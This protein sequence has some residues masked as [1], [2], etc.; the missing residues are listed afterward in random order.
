MQIIAGPA[1]YNLDTMQDYTGIETPFYLY[2]M[3]LLERTL[4][5]A[6]ES[7]SRYG[8][9]LHY[10]IKANHEWE[11]LSRI[12]ARGIGADCVSGGEL[13]TAFYAGFSPGTTVF[14]GVG[15]TDEEIVFALENNIYCLNCESVEELE[16]VAGLAGQMG[17]VARVALRVNPGVDAHTHRHITTGLEENKFGIQPALLQKALDFCAGCDSIRFL[18]L[19][20]HIG[21]QITGPAPFL[22]LCERVNQLWRDY[23]ISEYGGQMLNLGGGLGI[24]YADPDGDPVP[25]FAAF[26]AIF[27]E[28]LDLPREVQVHFEPG[29]SLVGQCG[30][31]ITKVLYVKEGVDK[32]FTITDAGMTE[33]LRPAL[34]QAVHKIENLSSK[35]P[36]KR[37]DVVGPAC[38][39]TDI[40]ARQVSLPATKRGDLLA[41]RSAGAYGQSM[42]LRYNQRRQAQ[43]YFTREEIT[44]TE[45]VCAELLSPVFV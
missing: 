17:K 32:T 36:S 1:A 37:Y 14:A 40:F 5:A 2:D 12:A 4:S 45:N 34:Y 10:A 15:K 38:E 31:L 42:S 44:A 23:R 24:N 41:I 11:I 26:F 21:S 27:A 6:C 35:A 7:A 16:V 22:A 8:Y 39:S 9:H 20:F 13:S 25:D 18:G 43:A 30:T 19:H 3:A 29:R 33:L 28:N